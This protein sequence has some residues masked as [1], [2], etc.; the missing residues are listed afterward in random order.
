MISGLYFTLF[1]HTQSQVWRMM[2]L[3]LLL[4][5]VTANPKH[6]QQQLTHFKHVST[7]AREKRRRKRWELS[8]YWTALS[9]LFVYGWQSTTI[10]ARQR[11]E[12]A[13][14]PAPIAYSRRQKDR[15]PFERWKINEFR[16]GKLQI[17]ERES[18]NRSSNQDVSSPMLL[19]TFQQI[20]NSIGQMPTQPHSLGLQ[21]EEEDASS[22]KPQTCFPK[23]CKTRLT[24]YES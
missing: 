23:R 10:Q 8:I 19:L 17:G 9:F 11:E 24:F 15:I 1:F 13:A 5:Y 16:I 6:E 22:Y 20:L 14:Q 18:I 2:S 4:A 12:E 3:L 21:Q 7:L